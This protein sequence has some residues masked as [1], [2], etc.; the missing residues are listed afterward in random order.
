MAAARKQAR[1]STRRSKASKTPKTKGHKTK[2]PKSTKSS[3]PPKSSRRPKTSKPRKPVDANPVT[4]LIV[5]PGIVSAG[6][7]YLSVADTTQFYFK[8]SSTFD[9]NLNFTG[10]F[11]K[12]SAPKGQT[13]GPISAAGIAISYT[14]TDAAGNLTGGPYAI[15]WGNGVLQIT[16]NSD[17]PDFDPVAVVLRGL[18]H[19]TAIDDSYAIKWQDQNGQPVYIWSPQP[20]V[21][22]KTPTPNLVQKA[23]AGV[24]GPYDYA[25]TA[26]NQAIGGG[27]VKVGS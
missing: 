12:V 8:N 24:N 26:K 5:S 3:K 19:Y 16:I 9:L 1:K 18:I 6:Q 23:A 13:V 20:T 11:G 14:I 4:I 17:T 15:Q 7:E 10:P 21:I 27:T 25:L 2:S 22:N